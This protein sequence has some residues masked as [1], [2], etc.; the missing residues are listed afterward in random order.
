MD[1][2]TQAALGAAVGEAVLGKKMGNKA[3][4]LGAIAGT[5]PDLDVLSRLFIDNQIYG[6]VYH[7]GLTHS[8]FFTLIASP[9]FAW[10]THQYY[11]QKWHQN[12]IVQF[13]FASFWG[14]LYLIVLSAVGYLAYR[15]PSLITGIIGLSLLALAIPIG[16]TLHNNV[17][18]IEKTT[19]PVTFKE[20]TIMYGMAFLTHWIIDACT[21]YGTQI[22]EPFSRYRV[23]F[24]NISIVDP[25]YTVPLLVGLIGA[26]FAT[27]SSRRF[28]WNSTGIAISSA[29]MIFTFY[30]KAIMNQVVDLNLANQKIEAKSYIT[31]PSIFN[32]ILWQTTIETEDAY[33]YGNYS[34]L[35]KSPTIKF[36]KLPK[37]HDLLE[38]YKNDEFVGILLWFAQGYYNITPQEDGSLMFSNLRFGVM[39]T[40]PEKNIPLEDRYIF[41]FFISEENGKVKVEEDQDMERIQ[42]S[43]MAPVL[44]DRI[45]GREV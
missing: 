38:E 12:K 45:C 30:A 11:Q 26:F 14:L 32:T 13:L 29:Y 17:N 42:P 21:A 28:N 22:F 24:N 2:I 36:I 41:R 31:Y 16:R 6:L 3:I 5:I 43:D 4:L 20:W 37:N 25:M 34:L 27:R 18:F 19:N 10:L 44:W 1:S 39:G 9:I 15:S 23:A 40:L 7:R 8:I 33:Y 35:D